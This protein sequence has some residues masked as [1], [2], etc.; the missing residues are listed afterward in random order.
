[1]HHQVVGIMGSTKMH[2]IMMPS[3]QLILRLLLALLLTTE[4]VK[5]YVQ[6]LEDCRVVASHFRNTCSADIAS[7]NVE[8]T[9]GETFTCSNKS[10]CIEGGTLSGTDCS[11]TRKLCV[12]CRVDDNGVT[13][14]RVQ[15]N[16]LPDHCVASSSIKAKNFDYEVPFNPRQ[17]FGAW[18]QSFETQAELNRAVYPIH[19]QHLKVVAEEL[20]D[21]ESAQ[22][23]GFAINGV[24][25]QFANQIREDPVYPITVLN[26]Q[27]LDTCLG[28]NQRNSDSGMYH[29]HDISPCLF[30]T[31]AD[32]PDN[33]VRSCKDH[34]ECAR[35][36]TEWA[37]QGYSTVQT[38]TIIGISKDGHVMYGPYDESGEL[39][40]PHAVDACN[41]AWSSSPDSSDYFYVGTRWHP[42]LVGYQGPANFPQQ[43]E[44][45]IYAQCSLN[46]MDQ[47]HDY[48]AVEPNDGEVV[49]SNVKEQSGSGEDDGFG[50]N[51]SAKGRERK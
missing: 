28:H 3:F 38:K 17:E 20:G 13:M 33:S 27:P 9:P 47:Y 2:N 7:S 34:P 51:S 22:A 14:I 16:N 40:Q 8:S 24:A 35:N 4:E 36:I 30:S 41:G 15:T 44:D 29:Y 26:E 21:G 50:P 23:M 31:T 45:A 19:K 11:W 46:G 12:T 39:W 1:M 42:Y 10:R 6:S 32:L 25:F 18:T 49:T 43:Q 37:L 48:A 5:A